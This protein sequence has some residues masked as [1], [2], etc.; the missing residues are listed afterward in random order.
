MS[1]SR[2]PE[3]NPIIHNRIRLGVLTILASV[4]SASFNFLKEKIETT[5]G[6]LSAN[7]TKLEEVGYIQIQKSFKGK[8]PLTMCEITK[9][10]R[11]A[12]KDYIKAL[13]VYLNGI[14]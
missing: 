4:E 5:D 3:L 12:L 13:E 7:L 11:A 10:G 1:R 14:E 2:L 6:N 8:R 9:K